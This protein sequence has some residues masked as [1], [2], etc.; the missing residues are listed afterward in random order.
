[1]RPHPGYGF[2]FVGPK[3]QRQRVVD[4]DERT[5]MKQIV[6]WRFRVARN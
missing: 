2:R 6:E 5:V 1:M 3:G 4:R